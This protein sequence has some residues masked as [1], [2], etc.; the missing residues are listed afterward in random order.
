MSGYQEPAPT[1]EDTEPKTLTSSLD[2]AAVEKDA[3]AVDKELTSQ[4]PEAQQEPVQ[5]PAPAVNGAKSEEALAPQAEE[6]T[7]AAAPVEEP[8][9]PLES[10]ESQVQPEKPK[11]PEPTPAASP[12][13]QAPAQ[14]AAPPKPAVPKTWASLAAAASKPAAAAT[15]APQQAQQAPAQQQQQ[16]KPAMPT[17]PSAAPSAPAAQAAPAAAQRDASPATTSG[18]EWTAVG[19]NHNRTQSRAAAPEPQ[20]QA[21]RGYIRNVGENIKGPELKEKLSQFGEL[22]HFDVNRQRVSP[23][24]LPHS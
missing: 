6:E 22:T 8:T 24:S 17:K 5:A 18:D 10:T 1:A 16:A 7:P 13:K 14:P 12:P 2:P 20:Q 9:A 3:Q 15:P 11:D 19:A 23:Q 4:V 21:G